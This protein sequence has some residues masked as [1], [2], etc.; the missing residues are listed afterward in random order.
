MGGGEEAGGVAIVAGGVG[1][2]R[3]GDG[4]GARGEAEPEVEAEPEGP[5]ALA[6]TPHES[7]RLVRGMRRLTSLFALCLPLAACG[8]PAD[9]VPRAHDQRIATL[10]D[11]PVELQPERAGVFGLGRQ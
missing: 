4:G 2:E 11:Q 8:T 3:V 10:E 6:S 1:A 9:R 5:R 7:G